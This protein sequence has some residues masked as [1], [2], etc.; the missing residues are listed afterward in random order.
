M[1]ESIFIQHLLAVQLG[2]TAESEDEVFLD[3]PEVVLRLSVS[4]AEHSARVSTSKDMRNT[5]SIAID[6]D[7]ACEGIRLREDKTLK[8]HEEANNENESSN[9]LGDI[10]PQRC[11]KRT[12]ILVQVKK[13]R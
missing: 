1:V 4:E 2:R 7:V 13:T 10:K 5:V 11:T 8:C 3:A 12:K 9:H 6:R